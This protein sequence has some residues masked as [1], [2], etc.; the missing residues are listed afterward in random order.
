MIGL[1]YGKNDLAIQKALKTLKTKIDPQEKIELNLEDLEPTHFADSVLTPNMF[2]FKNLV[3]ANADGVAQK[4]FLKFIEIAGRA[5]AETSVVFVLPKSLR[6][7]SKI[8]KAVK[9]FK[10]AE[11]IKVEEEKDSII[12]D[13]LDAVFNKNRP[14]AYASLKKL[15]DKEEP[16]FKTHSMLVYQLRNVAKTKF[17]AKVSA[18]PFVKRKLAKQAEKFS[19]E[20]LLALYTHFYETDRDMKL[21]LVPDNVLNVVSTEKVL[22]V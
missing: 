1:V 3:V 15:Q 21:G 5:P 7:N 16:P 19:Q 17:G 2:G 18:P 4:E 20:D 9:A 8:I 14:K 11:I 13:F 6:S 12:F 10:D 22:E